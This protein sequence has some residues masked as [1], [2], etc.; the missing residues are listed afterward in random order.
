MENKN[1]KFQEVQEVE[2]VDKKDIAKFK[3]EAK[4]ATKELQNW[5]EYIGEESKGME[6][7]IMKL[8]LFCK[9]KDRGS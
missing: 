4:M 6:K 2:A 8:N 3:D 9:D 5:E 7:K 1:T